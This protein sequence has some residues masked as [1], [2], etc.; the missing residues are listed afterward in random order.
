MPIEIDREDCPEEYRQNRWWKLIYGL[1]AKADHRPEELE[2]R[3][4]N[5]LDRLSTYSGKDLTDAQQFLEYLERARRRM[6]GE[7]R[8]RPLE[9]SADTKVCFLSFCPSA[10]FSPENR[11]DEDWFAQGIAEVWNWA[12][13]KQDQCKK[14]KELAP[15]DLIILKKQQRLY[16]TVRIFGFGI[17]SGIKGDGL[18][19]EGFNKRSLYVEWEKNQRQ[20]LDVDIHC[21]QTVDMK[22]PQ[23]LLEKMP[24]DFF[25][26]CNWDRN[27]NI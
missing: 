27:K 5:T 19:E 25:I 26:W 17:V 23:E 1:E 14:F 24:D 22:T 20:P 16:V 7:G 10:E 13:E 2:R 11:L 4:K 6:L 15:G 12:G 21:S 8:V 9:I 3:K 18:T